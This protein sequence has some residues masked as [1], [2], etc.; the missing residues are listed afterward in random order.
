MRLPTTV[1]SIYRSRF[2]RHPGQRLLSAPFAMQ[3]KCLVFAPQT[4]YRLYF[5]LAVLLD[6]TSA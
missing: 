2:S 5:P 6:A 1:S 4:F 3:Y